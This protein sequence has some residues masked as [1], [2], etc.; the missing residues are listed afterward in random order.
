MGFTILLDPYAFA[1]NE[2]G[3]DWGLRVVASLCREFHNHAC[4]LIC[5]LGKDQYVISS[6]AASLHRLFDRLAAYN[7]S[8]A[9]TDASVLRI[10]TTSNQQTILVTSAARWHEFGRSE[11]GARHKS[12]VR[13][14]VLEENAQPPSKHAAS[15]RRGMPSRPWIELSLKSEPSRELQRQWERQCHDDWAQ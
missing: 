15:Q 4:Q 9:R 3:L 12:S 5:Q 2:R 8:A 10:P 1:G 14:V 11:M 6:G 13:A 7:G